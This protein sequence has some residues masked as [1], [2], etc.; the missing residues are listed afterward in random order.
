MGKKWS[1]LL[2][3]LACLLLVGVV[4]AQVS[5]NHDLSWHVVAGGGREWM[6]SGSYQ[7]NGTLGQFAIGPA[8]STGHF[9]GAGYWYGVE[10][11]V[12]LYLPIIIKL[13]AP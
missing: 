11:G 1:F 5:P 4:G 10:R 6:A 13:Q 12:A 8:T 7:V 3:L 2:A 9:L